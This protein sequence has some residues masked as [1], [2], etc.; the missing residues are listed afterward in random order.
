MIICK[1][2]VTN[3]YISIYLKRNDASRGTEKNIK[4]TTAVKQVKIITANKQNKKIYDLKNMLTY[5]FLLFLFSFAW[6]FAA[7]KICMNKI[8][9]LNFL[10]KNHKTNSALWQKNIIFSF[11]LTKIYWIFTLLNFSRRIRDI[12]SF[13]YFDAIEEFLFLLDIK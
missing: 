12:E 9:F 2:L 13:F 11:L 7:Q 3:H 4:N 1:S 5:K 6:Y 10:S 8:I